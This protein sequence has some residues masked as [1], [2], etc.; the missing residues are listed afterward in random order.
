MLEGIG[1]V[2]GSMR[3][4]MSAFQDFVST[5][6]S[7][8]AVLILVAIV[9]AALFANVISP[10]DPDAQDY[11]AVLQPPS[12]DHFLGTDHLG[13]DLLSR[14]I[15]GS[16][17][18]LFIGLASVGLAA[19]VGS[20]LGLLS[21][22]ASGLVDEALMRVMD[23][24][25][26]FPSV[27]LA[28][29]I[30]AALGPGTLTIVVAIAVADLP[31]FARLT[32]GQ[33]LSVRERDFVTAARALGA[34]PKRLIFRHIWPHV[35]T[36]V[37]VMASL[38]VGFAI[39]TEAALSFLGLGVQPPTSSWGGILRT[40]FAYLE[41]AP[42]LSAFSGAAILIAVLGLNLLADSLRDH[43]DPR[44]STRPR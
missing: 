11:M 40:G 27:L 14:L 17:V 1:M 18:A 32:R 44:A 6:R 26:A 41:R 38:H 20:I 23:A 37:V 21:G 36:P 42:W 13:R 24:L 34:K 9:G 12:F 31:V 43:N 25:L 5:P 8:S 10:M 22:Y 15:H 33:V 39:L 30:T 3:S 35:T 2:R 4:R 28:L 19:V 16:R 7:A 29:G